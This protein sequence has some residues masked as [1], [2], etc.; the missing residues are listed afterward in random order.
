MNFCLVQSFNCTILH[1]SDAVPLVS[2]YVMCGLVSTLSIRFV[3]ASNGA[4]NYLP[5]LENI[6]FLFDLMEFSLNISGGCRGVLKCIR[7]SS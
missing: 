7:T 5:T 3:Q 4:L 2:V 1:N 6:S